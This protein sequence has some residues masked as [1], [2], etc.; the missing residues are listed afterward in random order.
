MRHLSLKG[1]R[2][3]TES[4]ERSDAQ[5]RRSVRECQST[6]RAVGHRFSC[7][8]TVRLDKNSASLAF[9]SSSLARVGPGDHPESSATVPRFSLALAASLTQ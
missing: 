5:F 9:L 8:A 1:A 3:I 4:S 6:D 2:L 7:T